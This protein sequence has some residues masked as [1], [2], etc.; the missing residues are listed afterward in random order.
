MDLHPI[1]VHF[2]IALLVLYSVLEVIKPLTK[3]A[4]WVQIRAVFVIIGTISAFVTLST[5]EGAEHLY[6]NAD[7]LNVL[8]L[9]SLLAN[10]TT[11]IYAVLAVCYLF[12]E[13]ETILLPHIPQSMQKT[14]LGFKKI[15]SFILNTPIA[16]IIAIIG[17]ITLSLVGTLGGIL[18]Y[19]PDADPI[20]QLVYR[21]LFGN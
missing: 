3:S 15:F 19:G 10:I 5:G 11:Y 14:A 9:H 2:P 4:H 21:L 12:L 18:V 17:F 13:F 7:R 20:T 1:F 8:E 16:S 6:K